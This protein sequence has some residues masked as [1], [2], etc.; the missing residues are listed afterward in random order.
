MTCT[1]HSS[2]TLEEKVREAYH[3]ILSASDRLPDDN[4]LDAAAHLLGDALKDDLSSPYCREDG[5]GEPR[6][7]SFP[8]CFRHFD[9]AEAK[10]LDG[11]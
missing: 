9:I 6:M 8:L 3:G 10:R 5:C 4:G 11:T 2:M 1:K 7:A